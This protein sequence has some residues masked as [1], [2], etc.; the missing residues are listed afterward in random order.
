VRAGFWVLISA[1]IGCGARANPPAAEPF[2]ASDA[3][4]ANAAYQ[5]YCGLCPKAE[6]CCLD[7]SAFA[8][9]NWSSASGA[10]LRAM[11][12]YYECQRAQTLLESMHVE[13]PLEPSGSGSFNSFS[14]AGHY[15]LS[16]YP[17]ACGEFSETMASELDR[18]RATP[19]LHEPGAL[20]ICAPRG[21]TLTSEP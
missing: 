17:H 21:S 6:T 18:A 11:R 10:Y 9:D 3:A 4:V 20:V 12:G 19:E 5:A 7:E 15:Q 13:P 1:L 2:R 14:N 16:C 8:P